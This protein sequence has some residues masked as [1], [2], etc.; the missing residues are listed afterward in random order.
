LLGSGVLRF[1]VGTALLG[2]LSSGGGASKI[3]G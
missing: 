2:G 3:F 1:Q